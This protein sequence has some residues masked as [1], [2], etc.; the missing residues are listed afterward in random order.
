MLIDSDVV[1]WVLRRQ[2]RAVAAVEALEDRRIS[3]ITYMEVV[4]GARDKRE[5][6]EF[7]DL[8]GDHGFHVLPLTEN[9]GH[10]ASIYVEEHALSV[11]M[12]I[13]DALIAATAV[14][15]ALPLFTGNTKHY[16]VI[17][18]LDLQRF[19]P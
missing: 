6:C 14:E 15:Y 12:G 5:V 4:R 8:L 18:G 7:R 2:L 13:P 19:R 10:R 3:V 1:I 17:P 16:R 11:A 9:I